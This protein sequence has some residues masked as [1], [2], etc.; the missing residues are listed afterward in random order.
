M[1]ESRLCLHLQGFTPASP[2]YTPTPA[3]GKSHGPG[4][5]DDTTALTPDSQTP[6]RSPS[7]QAASHAGAQC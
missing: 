1:T 2:T 6:A 5:V 4:K 3:P 7:G